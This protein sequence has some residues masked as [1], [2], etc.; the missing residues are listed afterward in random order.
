MVGVL[1][2]IL[3]FVKQLLTGEDLTPEAKAPQAPS[4]NGSGGPTRTELYEEAQRL[5]IEGRSKMDKQELERAVRTARS[6][7]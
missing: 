5:G 1:A 6:D 2:A 7:P 4:A 3:A